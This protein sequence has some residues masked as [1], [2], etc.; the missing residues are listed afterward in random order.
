[1]KIVHCLS[2]FLPAQTAGTEVYTWA[3][4][5]NLLKKGIESEILIPNYNEFNNSFYEY[6][7]IKV[8]KY[9]EP[10][11]ND[12]KLKMGLRPP[13]GLERFKNLLQRIN[14]DIVH[15][16][17][18]A[19]S[20]GIGIYHIKIAASL[21]YKCVMTFHLA[22]YSCK[23]QTLMYK[24]V[25]LCDGIIDENKCASCMLALNS[26]PAVASSISFLSKIIYKLGINVMGFR[27]KIMTGISY[28]FNIHKLKKDLELLTKKCDR[29]VVISKWYENILKKNN[30][31]ADKIIYIPQGLVPQN[32]AFTNKSEKP[33]ANMI[34]LL[35]LGRIS[36]YKGLHLLLDS[37][38]I[39]NNP[40][41][42][43]DIYGFDPDDDYAKACKERIKGMPNIEFRGKISPERVVTTMSNYDGLILP[44]TFSEMSPLVIQ[45]AFAAKI[46][47]IASDVYGNA[48]QI[49]NGKNGW[50][51]KY[52]DSDDL[53]RVLTELLEQPS[54][55]QQ[56]KK[57]IPEV[58]NFEKI[59]DDYIKL[60]KTILSE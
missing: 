54:M 10:S 43:I 1:M 37:M 57:Y 45:E 44:S 30:V 13:D 41:I 60:Y 31:P 23:A 3:L 42:N 56:A 5:K 26:P 19:G 21:G 15:F 36:K 6:D 9:A 47:V 28:P 25:T 12:K 11:I 14:P 24:G 20:S 35:F 59:S 16:H 53:A 51:F 46:P 50:L 4:C 33:G 32:I 52:N 8:N 48:E 38:K 39:I 58:L 34:R 40:N 22:N 17:E 2:H 27:S 29:V 55:L 49:S 7:S 18:L